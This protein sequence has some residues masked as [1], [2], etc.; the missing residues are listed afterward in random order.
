M[1]VSTAED[2]QA[3]C[4]LVPLDRDAADVEAAP[5]RGDRAEVALVGAPRAP[6]RH[7]LVAL[8]DLVL[9]AAL[10]VGAGRAVLA[11]EPD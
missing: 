7:D 6:A 3:T 1:C 11:K 9:D 8:G 5:R 10:R 2:K 4:D